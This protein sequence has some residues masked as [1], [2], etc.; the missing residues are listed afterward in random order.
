MPKIP[1]EYKRKC[2]KEK[3][4]C[5]IERVRICI[6]NKRAKGHEK[7][8]KRR[9][10]LYRTK[11]WS[12]LSLS[13]T[14]SHYNEKLSETLIALRCDDNGKVVDKI[15]AIKQEWNNANNRNT[16]ESFHLKVFSSRYVHFF[17]SHNQ[18]S[19]YHP[20]ILPLKLCVS[21]ITL[22]SSLILTLWCQIS[23]TLSQRAFHKTPFRKCFY[24]IHIFHPW[25]VIKKTHTAAAANTISQRI[26]NKNWIAWF[27]CI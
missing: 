11:P 10:T 20:A 12:M 7:Y 14:H 22:H 21:L 18:L 2:E 5:E 1:N 3:N 27:H 4:V 24:T 16:R 15:F 17:P 19:I 6:L 8:G 25:M 9:E 13:H 26:S 23:R